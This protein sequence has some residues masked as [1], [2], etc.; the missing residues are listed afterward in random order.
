MTR[1]L[2][3]DFVKPVFLMLD[4]ARIRS[5][6]EEEEEDEEEPTQRRLTPRNL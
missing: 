2:F 5:L 6:E 3:H 4:G 1:I